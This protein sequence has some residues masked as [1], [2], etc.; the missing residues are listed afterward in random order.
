MIDREIEISY[1]SYKEWGLKASDAFDILMRC[2]ASYNAITVIQ[3]QNR[4]KV[5]DYV[6][7]RQQ[8]FYF[9]KKYK[10]YSLSEIG[11][12]TTLQ[13]QRFYN[14]ATV[15]HA[16]NKVIPNLINTDNSFYDQI[17]EMKDMIERQF[18]LGKVN[19]PKKITTVT[20]AGY[21][22]DSIKS[23]NSKDKEEIFV[24]IKFRKLHEPSQQQQG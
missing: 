2:V 10:I 1:N 11:K 15:L 13:G 7:P 9:A 19:E 14:H 8:F 22:Y 16:V 18:E 20:P 12:K 6:F 3:M 4:T 5:G 23:I 24:I 21:E 17:L